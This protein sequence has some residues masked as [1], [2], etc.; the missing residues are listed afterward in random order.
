[1]EPQFPN[2]AQRVNHMMT[3]N[4]LASMV[5]KAPEIRNAALK[6]DEC[7][8]VL[9]HLFAGQADRARLS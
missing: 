9:P 2:L 5:Q 6:V 3:S 8:Q 7:Q 1:M 4:S